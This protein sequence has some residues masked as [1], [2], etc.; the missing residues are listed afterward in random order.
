MG[1]CRDVG[2]RGQNFSYKM[3]KFW[4]TNVQ[5]VDYKQYTADY[6]LYFVQYII[7]NN[8]CLR[9]DVLFSPH[10]QNKLYVIL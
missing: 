8:V 5:F 7:F 2:Q 1:K 4:R 3:N 10:T 6:I 9:I